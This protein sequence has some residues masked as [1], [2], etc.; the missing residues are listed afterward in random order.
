MSGRRFF[1]RHPVLTRHPHN[2]NLQNWWIGLPGRTPGELIP[3]IV[4]GHHANVRT[5]HS[6]Q[7]A[8]TAGGYGISGLETFG[9][10]VNQQFRA[11]GAFTE[12]Y[13]YAATGKASCAGAF[14]WHPRIWPQGSQ[15]YTGTPV[16]HGPTGGP[17]SHFPWTD[18]T[19]YLCM[20]GTQRTA[21]T[22]QFPSAVRRRVFVHSVP[23]VHWRLY[24]DGR[25]THSTAG[26]NFNEFDPVSPGP[27]FGGG[28]GYYAH[29]TYDGYKFWMGQTL[30]DPDQMAREDFYHYSR[31]YRDLLTNKAFKFF[32]P[33]GSTPSGNPWYYQAQQHAVTG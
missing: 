17:A 15:G 25:L 29:G 11:P 7:V 19:V 9:P 23:N 27:L 8:W 26:P 16:E 5:G 4:R 12:Q 2:A 20:F 6:N 1:G 13:P 14:W 18:G 3:D 24:E 28:R 10:D 21:F 30:P 31:G 22:S 33:A 32:N